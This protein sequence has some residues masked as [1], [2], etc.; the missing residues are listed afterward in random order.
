MRN[1]RLKAGRRT[2]TAALTA[3]LAAAL[4][5]GTAACGVSS[6]SAGT[7]ATTTATKP[8][9]SATPSAS[10]NADPLAGLNG[11][12]I[13]TKAMANTKAA[14]TVRISGKV[15]ASGQ[16]ITLDLTVVHGKGCQGTLAVGKQ[17][18]FRLIYNGTTVW[19]MPDEAFYR[20]Q[21]AS[22]AVLAILNGKYLK[23]NA[24]GGLGQMAT[25]CSLSALLGGFSSL[26]AGFP[27]GATTTDD[28]QRA[29]R[30]SDTAD[31]AYLDISD[32]AKPEVLL[33]SDPSSGQIHF[34]YETAV[35][36]ITP[37]PAS[38]VLDGSKYGF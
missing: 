7:A 6:S 20:G 37:P 33:L 28:G 3:I 29:I 36:A 26:P 22:A 11:Q 5:A 35:V 1:F 31:S 19:M 10:T 4:A 34:S 2:P 24:T 17:G 21:G 32:A 8:A 9:T 15:S 25:L 18:S 14:T 27:R 12:Q 16:T 38:M 23:E 13:F 30:I